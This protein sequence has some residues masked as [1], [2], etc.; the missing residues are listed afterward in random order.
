MV[1][2]EEKK[3]DKKTLRDKIAEAKR[4]LLT[5][6]LKKSSGELDKPSEINNT[7][8]EV[9]RLFTELNKKDK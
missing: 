8:K 7:K 1:K 3:L 2:K 6:R 9:A 4:K 5:L